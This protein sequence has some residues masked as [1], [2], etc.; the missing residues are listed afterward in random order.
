MQSLHIAS[1]SL[2]IA[3]SPVHIKITLIPNQIDIWWS[4]ENV[5]RAEWSSPDSFLKRERGPYSFPIDTYHLGICTG[6]H[7]SLHDVVQYPAEFWNYIRQRDGVDHHT[8]HWGSPRRSLAL[9]PPDTVHL[10]G[11]GAATVENWT[12]ASTPPSGPSAAVCELHQSIT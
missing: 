5:V 3:S 12:L 8:Y 6:H 1:E 2:H 7:A 9:H 4:A 10:H 11:S